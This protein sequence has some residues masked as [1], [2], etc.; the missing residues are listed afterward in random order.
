MQNEYLL[1]LWFEIK[2]PTPAWSCKKNDT[3]R[4]A[5]DIVED[6]WNNIEIE[7]DY[8]KQSSL[9]L[10]NEVVPQISGIRQQCSDSW[11]HQKLIQDIK[12]ADEDWKSLGPY[13]LGV[14]S[15]EL[16]QDE[17]SK[18]SRLN[19]GSYDKNP[20]TFINKLAPL[21]QLLLNILCSLVKN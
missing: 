14:K 19:I 11:L 10:I 13:D 4:R 12:N 8:N 5:E 7:F 2:S 18:W 1:G 17:Q 21:L 20:Y 9:G 6:I 16:W 3:R 15:E